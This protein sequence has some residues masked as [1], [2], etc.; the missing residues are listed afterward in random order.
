M[1]LVQPGA[2]NYPVPCSKPSARAFAADGILSN[3]W[4]DGLHGPDRA[5]DSRLLE[6][7]V[8]ALSRYPL[9]AVRGGASLHG[10]TGG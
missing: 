6:D 9:F 3:S 4:N 8:I 7:I 10:V 1:T 2:P 5:K